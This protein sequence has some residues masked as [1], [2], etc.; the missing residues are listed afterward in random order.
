M[1]ACRH[2]WQ[3]P[4]KFAKKAA[5]YN[6]KLM[7]LDRMTGSDLSTAQGRIGRSRTDWTERTDKLLH[8]IMQYLA[9]V[10]E[11]DLVYHITEGT[12][13]GGIHLGSY[14]DVD[15]SG[16]PMDSKSCTGIVNMI[17]SAC[18]GVEATIGWCRRRR[19]KSTAW[20]TG[21]SVIV[22]L[23]DCMVQSLRTLSIADR[24]YSNPEMQLIIQGDRW[25]LSP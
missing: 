6:G 20:S 3:R 1:A 18:G 24:V 14:V 7:Y 9:S 15:H 13:P 10:P 16:N 4:G 11:C 5:R 2:V 21:E 8:R 17:H 22:A 19:K 25:K 23:A 12:Q